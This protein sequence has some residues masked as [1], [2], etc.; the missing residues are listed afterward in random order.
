MTEAYSKE[1]GEGEESKKIAF[2]LFLRHK[3]LTDLFF[4]G[5]EIL[6]WK[7]A[8]LGKRQRID[9]IFHKWL[10]TKIQQAGDKL[11]LVPRLH[12]KTTWVKLRIIQMLLDNPNIRIGLFS[13]TTTLVEDE[14]AD[15]KRMFIHPAIMELF[16]DL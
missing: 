11:I 9:P 5:Y 15:I 8:K 6:G 3:A 7:N 2:R 10:A 14:L 1:Y 16:P 4:L 12:L 13:V